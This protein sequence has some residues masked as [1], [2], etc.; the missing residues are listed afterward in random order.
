MTDG[1][2]DDDELPFLDLVDDPVIRC[3]V[4]IKPGLSC[5]FSHELIT[6][7]SGNQRLERE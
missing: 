1:Y 6:Y 4:R 3:S 7:F 5:F 2:D